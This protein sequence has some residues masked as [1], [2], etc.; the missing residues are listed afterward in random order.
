M[1]GFVCKVCGFISID[2]SAPDKCPAC[3]APKTS[4]QEKEEAVKT[5]KDANNLTELEKKH[6]P[7]ITIVKKCGLIPE[8]CQDVHVRVGQ[9]QHPMTGEHSIV[10]I[11]FYIDN[12]FISR[13]ILIP[14][15]LNPAAAL[16]LK[17]GGGKLTVIELCNLHGA[18][19]NQADL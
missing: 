6:I 19:I 3:G 1:K 12:Q 9:I 16:H 5:A 10:H 18:W 8:G 4:F 17:A 7:V 11:D 15:K 14:D 13:V 2:G